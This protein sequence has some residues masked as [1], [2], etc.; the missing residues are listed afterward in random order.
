MTTKPQKKPLD[1]KSALRPSLG[2]LFV[3]VVLVSITLA[4][5]SVVTDKISFT[6]ATPVLMTIIG[7]LGTA[8]TTFVYGRS[9]EKIAGKDEGYT[10]DVLESDFGGDNHRHDYGD[11][12]NR[13]S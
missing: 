8:V 10:A 5:Y 12:R 7:I 4:C 2:W 3:Y 1:Y 13:I 6:E 9:K 11:G